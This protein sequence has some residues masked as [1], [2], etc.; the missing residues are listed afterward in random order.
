[1]TGRR[2]NRPRLVTTTGRGPAPVR[3][4]GVVIID[5]TPYIERGFLHTVRPEMVVPSCGFAPGTNLEIHI[6]H[7]RN[8]GTND[9]TLYE[10]VRAAHGCTVVVKGYDY[11][12]VRAVQRALDRMRGF[13]PAP[14]RHGCDAGGCE[15]LYGSPDLGRNDI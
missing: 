11:D 2:P 8:V 7:A 3:T 10:I 13:A 4:V 14:E 9:P 12:G 15:L 5:L 1:M 6:G